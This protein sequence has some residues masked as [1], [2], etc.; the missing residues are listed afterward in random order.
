MGGST[1]GADAQAYYV[2]PGEK[3]QN[4]INAAKD[5]DTINVASGA[6]L[7]NLAIDKNLNINGADPASTTING[8]YNRD[9]VIKIISPCSLSNFAIMNGIQAYGNGG[10]IQINLQRGTTVSLTNC[11]ISYNSARSG[12]GISISGGNV[13]LS[14]CKIYRN[15]A[16]DGDGGGIYNGGSLTLLGGTTIS[17][18]AAN[19][20]P[21]A[22]APSRFNAVHGGG[23]FNFKII[24]GI[25]GTT[26]VGE[27]SSVYEN[28]PD[29]IYDCNPWKIVPLDPTGPR[30]VLW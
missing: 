8:N 6:Y 24:D 26:S 12:G 25:G 22:A 28:T 16:I 30:P 27:G 5:G 18:N 9:S 19:R 13:V 4:A 21:A 1:G 14:G 20:M 7:E 10:G 15:T 23:I 17:G 29:N 2:R 11:I 3:I